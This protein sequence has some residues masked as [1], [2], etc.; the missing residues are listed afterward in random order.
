MFSVFDMSDIDD[1][2]I[3]LIKRDF[4]IK[5]T[6]AGIPGTTVSVNTSEGV[7]TATPINVN[8]T[9]E[10][11]VVR[12][13]D[14]N[15][16][17]GNANSVIST[18][19]ITKRDSSLILPKEENNYIPIKTLFLYKKVL[20]VGS[21]VRR[22]IKVLGIPEGEVRFL[23]FKNTGRKDGEFQIMLFIET[24]PLYFSYYFFKGTRQ[25]VLKNF[26]VSP[27]LSAIHWDHIY[28]VGN[29]IW[30]NWNGCS[31]YPNLPPH[32]I[33]FNALIETGVN[34]VDFSYDETDYIENKDNQTKFT[35]GQ[36]PEIKNYI[37]LKDGLLYGCNHTWNTGDVVSLDKIDIYIFNNTN[38]SNYDK[39]LYKHIKVYSFRFDKI[40]ASKYF[41]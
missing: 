38:L 17:I 15:I 2:I 37:T 6:V 35:T 34:Q 7:I 31:F 26:T 5:G 36:P 12:T 28:Y 14:G 30:S 16:A 21:H 18:Q 3:D 10:V 29:N 27:D 20:Y 8:S 39:S 40:F 9:G 41:I 32:G 24:S 23:D 25:V 33:I 11:T 4:I 13:P 22:P 1:K 19:T